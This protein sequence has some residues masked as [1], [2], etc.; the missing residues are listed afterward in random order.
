ME[1]YVSWAGKMK[2]T[3]H[4]PSGFE[5]SF[6]SPPE[7]GGE[8]AGPQPLEALLCCI[9]ACSAMD[10]ISILKKKR[11]DVTAYR[12]EVKGDRPPG[13][14]WPRPFTKI[15]VRHI[16]SGKDL[17]EAAVARAAELSDTKYCSVTATLREAPEVT[18]EWEVN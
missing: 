12:V 16:L 2:F 11:Q 14:Q 15:V 7:F 5:F 13:G 3:A 18:S 6:D 10:V 4:P 17:D 8:G 9:A 1:V